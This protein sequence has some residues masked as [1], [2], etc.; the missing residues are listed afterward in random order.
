[1]SHR[2][3][4]EL[5]ALHGVRVLGGPSVEAI[6]DRFD[7]P[8]TVVREQLLDAQAVGWV[9]RHDFF[10]ETWS[11]TELGRQV[12]ERML[13]DELASTGTE[14][15]VRRAHREFLPL[16]TRHG[17]A[18]SDWQLTPA[19]VGVSVINDHTDP[20]RDDRVLAD[21]ED[22]DREFARLAASLAVALA[23]FDGYAQLHTAALARASAGRPEWIDAPDRASCQ[24]VWIQFHE[25]LLATL[26]I[27]RGTD[28]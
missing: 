14:G 8:V 5:L 9:S 16:N 7:L 10:G 26:G 24:L 3:A 17:Q 4:P 28:T 23:R 19:G 1:M 20:V 21:L 13:A 25:D 27:L 12:N 15:L 22:I 2:S 11:L 6:A 18:C